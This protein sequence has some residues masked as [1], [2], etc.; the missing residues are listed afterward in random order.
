MILQNLLKKSSF[1]I[2]FVPK[3]ERGRAE[4]H[5][6]EGAHIDSTGSLSEPGLFMVQWSD[7][8]QRSPYNH[9]LCMYFL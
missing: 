1:C 4:L 2:Q 5:R 8:Q 9:V 7:D 6:Q 3:S